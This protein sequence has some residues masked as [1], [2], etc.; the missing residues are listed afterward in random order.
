MIA[1]A[2]FYGP[3]ALGDTQPTLS[4]HQSMSRKYLKAPEIMR[5]DLSTA[6]HKV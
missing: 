6:R 5:A 2:D 1:V 3:D 4:K